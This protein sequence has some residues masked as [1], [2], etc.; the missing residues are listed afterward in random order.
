MRVFSS[1]TID[2]GHQLFSRRPLIVKEMKDGLLVDKTLYGVN[3]RSG[4]TRLSRERARC[5]TWGAGPGSDKIKKYM[6]ARLT[7]LL[8][9]DRH[10]DSIKSLPNLSDKELAELRMVGLGKGAS[11]AKSTATWASKKSYA[12][13]VKHRPGVPIDAVMAEAT[14]NVNIRPPSLGQL[15]TPYIS[16]GPVDS[17]N[18]VPTTAEEQLTISKALESWITTSVC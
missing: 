18:H 11:K 8:G 13:N 12:D 9:K 3:A 15:E 7:R 5:I 17:H 6:D 16:G 4:R 1:S 2:Q 10:P 14:N